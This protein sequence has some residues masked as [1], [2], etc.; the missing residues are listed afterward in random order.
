MGDAGTSGSCPGLT[1]GL[2][3]LMS[4]T[5]SEAQR[6]QG[7]CF[8]SHSSSRGKTYNQI[9]LILK[10]TFCVQSPAG[11]SKVE[12]LGATP[13]TGRQAG[14]AK[15]GIANAPSMSGEL[16]VFGRFSFK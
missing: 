8:R 9:W 14:S 11:P 7:I 15:A 5:T 4:P 10:S 1:T 16:L 13:P 2:Q 12:S 6:G 3:R